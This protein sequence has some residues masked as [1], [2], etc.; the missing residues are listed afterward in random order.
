MT[1][2]PVSTSTP[3]TGFINPLPLLVC[4][5]AVPWFVLVALGGEEGQK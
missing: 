1:Q 2:T 5:Q 4:R 3:I